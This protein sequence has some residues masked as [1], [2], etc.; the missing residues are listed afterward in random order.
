MM[1]D[2]K[3]LCVHTITTKPWPLET[4]AER[5]ASAGVRGITVW[6]NAL[7]GRDPYQAGQLLRDAG[8]DIVSLCRGGFFPST[9]TE[10]RQKA[11]DDNRRAIAEAYALEAPHV[12]LV[13]G[14]VPGLPLEESRRH[15]QEGIE[16]VLP[17]CHQTGVK[18]AI[19][20]LHPMYADSRSA[21]NTMRQANDLC[22]AIGDP[23]IGVAADVYHLWWDPDLET[24]I[25]RCGAMDRLFAFHVCDWRTP[26]MDLLNDR[27][28]M[29]EGCIPIRRI[30]QWVE[31][32]GFHGY[33]E[34]EIFSN[35]FWAMDQDE[36]LDAIVRSYRTHVI[37]STSQEPGI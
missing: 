3:R 29:G 30:R 7:E 19:E 24:E 28:L 16:A 34:V 5:Y 27:G 6:R 35:S 8:L 32:A 26:T 15:I 2:L 9:S 25:A 33:D 22:E 1:N 36:F 37:E 23:M 14:A 17:D 31:A 12:V 20:P 10:G 4:A 13:C 18:L 21:I 11:I